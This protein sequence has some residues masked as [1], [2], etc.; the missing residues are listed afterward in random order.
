MEDKKT[1]LAIDFNNCVF[2]SAY[3]Q[4]LTNSKGHNVNVIIAFFNKLKMLIDIV[5][6]TYIVFASDLT[7][8]RTFRRKL[9]PGY[10]AQ[11]K[12]M[13]PEIHEQMRTI[14]RLIA[15]LGYPTLNDYTYEADD[16]LGMISRYN[17]INGMN[18]V[19]ISSDRDLYQLVNK[20]TFIMTP[21]GDKVIDLSYMNENYKLT[22]DQWIELKML[23][24]DRSDNIPGIVGIGPKTALQLMQDFGSIKSIYENIDIIRGKTRELLLLG[25]DNLEITRKLVT[26]VTDYTLLDINEEKFKRKE[27]YPNEIR[28]ILYAIETSSLRPLFFYDLLPQG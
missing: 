23:Q 16:V 1:V 15:L 19:I 12:P 27:A 22:P 13:D 10:K 6:P 9:Y 25:K 5:N 17:M 8:E 26:I 4:P 21:R 2:A 24:G 14:S 18:T 11:R 3:G 28:D 20:H 7:R